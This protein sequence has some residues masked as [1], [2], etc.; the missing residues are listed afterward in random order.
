MEKICNCDVQR[1]IN[2]WLKTSDS[3]AGRNKFFCTVSFG[4][5]VLITSR[6]MRIYGSLNCL[7]T[8]KKLWRNNVENFWSMF[9]V[10]DFCMNFNTTHIMFLTSCLF[11]L[12]EVSC[13]W[14]FL[15][16]NAS[17]HS[18]FELF[19]HNFGGW[20]CVFCCYRPYHCISDIMQSRPQSSVC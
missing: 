2:T 14:I 3:C 6:N 16:Q 1:G 11:F 18:H 10:L 13:C 8:R 15:V 5:I 17:W 20:R 4:S 19:F 12:M 9:L 7:E